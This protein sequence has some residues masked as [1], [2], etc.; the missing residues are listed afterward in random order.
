[1]EIGI[2]VVIDINNFAGCED[3]FSIDD[4]VASKPSQGV[5][6]GETAC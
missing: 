4:V 1:M 5:K 3:N 6:I 2:L